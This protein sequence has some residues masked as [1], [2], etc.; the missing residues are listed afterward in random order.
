MTFKFGGSGG[1]GGQ[2]T[3]I[4]AVAEGAIANGAPC[5]QSGDGKI[6]TPAGNIAANAVD[7]DTSATDEN[8]WKDY[9][10]EVRGLQ[11]NAFQIK[12]VM[13][14][15]NQARIPLIADLRAIALAT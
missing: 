12:I 5:I 3:E 7:Y 6:A 10:Y 15:K 4:S 8:L 9:P 14:S 2:V 11:F 13:R 1:G